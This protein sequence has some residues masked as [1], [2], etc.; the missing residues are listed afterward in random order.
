MQSRFY[1]QK[2]LT[3]NSGGREP[4][5]GRIIASMQEPSSRARTLSSNL[6]T[7]FSMSS[8][9]KIIEIFSCIIPETMGPRILV[10]SR[11]QMFTHTH[12]SNLPEKF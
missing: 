1:K 11:K 6:D 8:Y 7:N 10:N 2:L 3:C 9:M 4:C 12:T 5:R